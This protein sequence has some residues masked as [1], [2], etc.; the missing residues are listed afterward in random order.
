VP[1]LRVLRDRRGYETTYLMHWFPEGHR[2]RSRVLYVFRTPAGVRVGRSA[3][4]RDVLPAI[5]RQYPGVDFDWPSIFENRQVV[6]S[7]PEL[8]R[9]RPRRDEPAATPVATEA[10]VVAEP[11]QPAPPPLPGAP[12]IPSAVEGETP[13]EQVAF[14]NRWYP[15]IRERIAQRTTDPMRRDALNALAERLSP[16]AW[17]DADATA[18]GLRQAA[19]ALDR[20]SQILTR[21]RRRVRRR[22]ATPGDS[23][24]AEPA[25]EPALPPEAPESSLDSAAPPGQDGDGYEV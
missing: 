24:S 16:L 23:G 14:L 25:G 6:E 1:F 7:A 19:E 5:E 18:A 8:R 2:Q 21:R 12:A 11:A 15:V 4:D 22:P 17:N 9:R 20:L 13:D 3:L 10:P